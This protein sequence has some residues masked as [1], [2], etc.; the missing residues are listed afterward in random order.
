MSKSRNRW[1]TTAALVA[2]G[3]LMADKLVLSALTRH[4]DS[5]SANIAELREQ[6]EHG[7]VT[8]DR[9]TVL[10]Q[11]WEIMQQG[12]LP[13]DVSAAEDHVLRA[14]ARW[15]RDSRIMMTSLVP[16]WREQ[17]EGYR[18]LECRATVQGDLED[19]ARF[20]LELE[21]DPLAV[22]LERATLVA[23]DER[24]STLTLDTLFTVLRLP[25]EGEE[26]GLL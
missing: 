15:A 6:V 9:E 3:V 10:R 2:V 4:W 1:L 22:R 24:G 13:A 7:R 5:Q 21:K 17:D 18:T 26:E 14:A 8:L 23:R 12:A 11:R 16:R 25:E 20:M 19:V